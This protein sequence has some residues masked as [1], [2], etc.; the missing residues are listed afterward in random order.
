MSDDLEPITFRALSFALFDTEAN[1][2]PMTE[3]G[4]LAIFSTRAMAARYAAAG[5]AAIKVVPVRI[6]PQTEQ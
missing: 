3:H 1:A 6:T 4:N 2:V 5:G